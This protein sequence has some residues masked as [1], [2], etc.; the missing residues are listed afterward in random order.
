MSALKYVIKMTKKRSTSLE[1]ITILLDR[2]KSLNPSSM[3]F[4]NK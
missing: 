4:K 2:T 1:V 3:D